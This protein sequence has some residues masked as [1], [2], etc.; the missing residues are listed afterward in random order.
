[1]V[2]Q[3]QPDQ[4]I[5]IDKPISVSELAMIASR[6][7]GDMVKAV[8]DVDQAKM[9]L[10]GELHADCE[11]VL[12]DSGSHPINLWGINLYPDSFG[13]EDFVEYDSMINIRPSQ[14]NRSRRVEDKG[15]RERI[16]LIVGKVVIHESQT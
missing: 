2:H 10:G 14:G 6:G 11:A 5:V 13:A 7:F 16:R 8:V 4:I 1:M 3:S 12:L 15:M 9:A